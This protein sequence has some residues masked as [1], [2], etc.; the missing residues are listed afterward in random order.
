MKK[1]PWYVQWGIII[2]A[3]TGTILLTSQL[4]W[5][6]P[7]DAAERDEVV[8]LSESVKIIDEKLDLVLKYYGIKYK[9]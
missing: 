9:E 3:L 8:E 6:M 5:T 2:A 4:G 1:K 7:W